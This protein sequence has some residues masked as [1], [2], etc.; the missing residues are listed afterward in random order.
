ME[1]A[2]DIR[3]KTV[4]KGGLVMVRS[5]CH[6]SLFLL[7]AIILMVSMTSAQ[8]VKMTDRLVLANKMHCF[9][10][11][12][13]NPT[14]YYWWTIPMHPWICFECGGFYVNRPSAWCSNVNAPNMTVQGYVEEINQ[15]KSYGIDG[16]I[17]DLTSNVNNEPTKFE[18]D[19]INF[20]ALVTAA[21]QVGDFYIVAQPDMTGGVDAIMIKPYMDAV[22]S[23]PA[24]LKID[25]LP[26][27]C[28]YCVG[29]YVPDEKAEV[30]WYAAQGMPIS[31]I[32]TMFDNQWWYGNNDYSFRDGVNGYP[33]FAK[34]ITTF[35]PDHP[36]T[37]RPDVLSY[38]RNHL[39][40]MPDVALQYQC[41]PDGVY[42][43]NH[44]T[45]VFRSVFE[46]GIANRN[47][48]VCW[49]MPN[50]WNDFHESALAPNSNMFMALAPL[51]KYYADWF[52]TGVQPTIE[53][54]S[55][56]VFHAS[57]PHTAVPSQYTAMWTASVADEVEAVA[58][59]T[60]PATLYIQSGN[61]V[62]SAE[63]GAGVQSLLEPFS[64]GYQ[65]AWVVRSGQTI[66][67]VTSPVPIRSDPLIANNWVVGYG[68]A[69]PPET[70]PLTNWST[71]YG[72]MTASTS[73]ASGMGAC[74]IQVLSSITGS[75][76]R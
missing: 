74:E 47:N 8:A 20:I 1:F 64:L 29:Y 46:W 16:F 22:A 19:R 36:N 66:C 63:V 39:P 10:P 55:V 45:Q 4:T 73:S 44:M 62:Y 60:A 53:K 30:N 26:L 69:Y 40:Y 2:V 41:K 54:D 58:I 17:V 11:M 9:P 59:L 35:S 23:S 27:I 56:S 18:N 32:P 67:S 57:Y 52:K 7:I 38:W 6:V 37:Y 65:K 3:T 12:G 14:S 48:G 72:T 5:K 34:A 33:S 28:P 76:P 42:L 24:Y 25:G 75:A 61:N 49:M 31:Y 15:A 68:S 21:E 50:N 13:I 70:V 51:H 43:D 71:L